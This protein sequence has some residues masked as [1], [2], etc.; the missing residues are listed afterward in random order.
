MMTGEPRRAT[1]TARTDIE[2]Y[3][4]DKEG[5]EDILRSRPVI[6]E[7]ISRVLAARAS[8]LPTS[9]EAARAEA[10]AVES[11]SMLARIRAFFG[12][13]RTAPGKAA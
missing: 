11:G 7:E 6:V 9:L 3:R 5:F 8:G 13:E 4:L 12:L 1:V 2:C 10:S